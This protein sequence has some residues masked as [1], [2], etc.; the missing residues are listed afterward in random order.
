MTNENNENENGGISMTMDGAQTGSSADS[1]PPL[2][3]GQLSDRIPGQ[4]V[5]HQLLLAHLQD[6]PR[7][8]ISRI[9]GA[10]LLGADSLSWY[11]GAL[12]EVAVGGVLDRLGPEWTV[13]HAVPVGRG[14]SDIDHVVIGPT[15]VFTLNSKSHTGQAVWSAKNILMIAGKKQRHIY[16]A[17]FEANRAAKLLS[18]AF[19]RPV[20]VNGAVVIVG[21]KSVTVKE[22][23]PRIAVV[24]Q[25]Q[26]L[27]WLTRRPTVLNPHQIEAI[28]AAAVQPR[29]WHQNPALGNTSAI[30]ADFATLKGLIDQARRRRISWFLG[31]VAAVVG[32]AS[33]ILPI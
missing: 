32:T 28:S 25:H 9:F 27:R 22:N 6:T 29:T 3:R 11:W 15:G 30:A 2:P 26:L 14:N 1:V 21:A 5:M 23:H 16:N 8:R 20:Y 12:G 18:S 7:S 33:G 4:S 13:L 31:T 19:G 10:R 24:T 17:E